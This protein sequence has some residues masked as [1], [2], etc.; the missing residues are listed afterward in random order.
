MRL[1]AGRERLVDCPCYTATFRAGLLKFTLSILPRWFD[2]CLQKAH[3]QKLVDAALELVQKQGV[4]KTKRAFSSGPITES[5]AEWLEK[6]APVLWEE[7]QDA[8]C[9]TNFELAKMLRSKRVGSWPVGQHL[10]VVNGEAFE[11]EAAAQAAASS[12]YPSSFVVSVTVGEPLP[13]GH[14]TA[15]AQSN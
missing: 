14:I 15:A 13:R 5:E 8:A 6:E 12:I 2:P 11:S 7:L 3:Y 9:S 4:R 1:F 10:Y